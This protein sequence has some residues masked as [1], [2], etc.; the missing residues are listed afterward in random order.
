M[1]IS[2]QWYSSV[3]VLIYCQKLIVLWPPE[4]FNQPQQPNKALFFI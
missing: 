1:I 3:A 2:I 4:G